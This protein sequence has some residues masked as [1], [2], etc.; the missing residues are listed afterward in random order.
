M[1]GA[2]RMADHETSS[3]A[4]AAASPRPAGPDA[5]LPLVSPRQLQA[6]QRT[7]G[8]RAVGRLLAQARRGGETEPQEDDP[9]YLGGDGGT[10]TT[11][12]P[13]AS[14]SGASGGG[15]AAAP[16]APAAVTLT[17][18][19][20]TARTRTG[21]GGYTYAVRW[22]LNN[23]DATTNG[24]IVQKL[25]FDLRRRKCVGGDDNFAK[26][27]WEAWEVRGGQI[28]VGTSTSR[29][30]ADTFQVPSTPDECGVNFEEG[31]AKFIPGYTAPRSWGRVAEA[32]SLPATET[33]PA[34]WSDAGTLKR[35]VR[36]SF[37]CCDRSDLGEISG[38][39]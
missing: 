10:A 13:A 3:R 14:G 33:E 19:T 18:S 12:P 20:V 9:D 22:G 29:H 32:G 15:S 38:E 27:Y 24:F 23:A 25:T 21:C 37:D 31:K 34:D 5:R 7:A 39:G 2:A 4:P 30:N 6:L 1:S 16:A 36:V 26:K 35:N 28:F 8:N 17:Y 11:A